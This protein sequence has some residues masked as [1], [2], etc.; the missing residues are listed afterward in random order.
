VG[1]KIVVVVD[2][3]VVDYKIVAEE[4]KIVVVVAVGD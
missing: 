3:I 4:K 1:Y 2:K